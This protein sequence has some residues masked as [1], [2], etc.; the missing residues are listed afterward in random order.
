MVTFGRSM[1]C[2]D[3]EPYYYDY[4]YGLDAGVARAVADHIRQCAHC[5]TQVRRLEAA[6]AE[7][8]AQDR[9]LQGDMDVVGALGL[10]F[11]HLGADITCAKARSFLPV[12]L[13]PSLEIRIPTPITVHVDH[14]RQCAEDLE[15]QAN[16]DAGC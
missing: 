8:E 16:D 13:V 14:C 5:R 9:M 15:N 12:L 6:I 3:A 2:T 10:H 11:A 4:L 7:S 1:F